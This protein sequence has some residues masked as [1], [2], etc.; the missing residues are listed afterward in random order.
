MQTIVKSVR[1]AAIALTLIGLSAAVAGAGPADRLFVSIHAGETKL[2]SDS[3]V[4]ALVDESMRIFMMSTRE[5]SMQSFWDHVSLQLQKEFSVARL[6]EGFK[7]FFNITKG[8]PLAGKS[9]I[10]TTKPSINGHGMLVVDGFYLTTPS[11]MAFR[12]IY[13][14]EG[15]TWKVAAIDVKLTNSNASLAKK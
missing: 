12:L 8:D 5:R 15:L 13:I 6:D 1:A 2:P 10:F 3:Q 7:S 14:A 11:R 9:P 4:V